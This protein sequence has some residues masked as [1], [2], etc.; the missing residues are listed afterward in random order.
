MDTPAPSAPGPLWDP[1]AIPAATVIPLRDGPGGLEVLML[2]RDKDLSFAGG[3]WVFP[4]GRIDPEDF[5]DG[6][7]SDGTPTSGRSADDLEAAARVAA[8]READEEAAIALEPATVRRWTHW[9]PPSRPQAEGLMSHRF[10]TAF[11]VG[12]A[13]GDTDDVTIDDGEI[14]AH[15]WVGPSEMLELH[16]AGEVTLAPPTFITLTQ[17]A[18]HRNPAEVLMAAPKRVDDIEH[19]ATRVGVIDGGW[20]ALYHDD[21]A[22]DGGEVDADGPRHRL[23]MGDR[24]HYERSSIDSERSSIDS[25]RDT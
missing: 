6:G 15:R 1:E 19:F 10:T 17:L 4:G 22:Y 21:V 18:G 25:E 16:A 8:L 24:W 12:V 5:P 9:T 3:M 14:R 23:H 2:R 13:I 20:V 11:F 7:R